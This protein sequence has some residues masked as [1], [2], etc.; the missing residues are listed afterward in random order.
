M[1]EKRNVDEFLDLWFDDKK[2]EQ[3]KMPIPENPMVSKLSKLFRVLKTDAQDEIFVSIEDYYSRQETSKKLTKRTIVTLIILLLM[4]PLTIAFGILFMGDRKYTF[5]GIM[6][7]FYAIIPF[8]MGFESRKPQT[9]ELIVIAV[10]SAIAVL[11]RTA[12][13][14]VPMFKPILA[15]IIISGVTFGPEAGF[16]VGAVS[17]FISNFFFGQGPWTPWQMFSAGIIGFVA[18]VLFRKGLLKRTRVS[19][20]L[21]GFLAAIFIYG[22]IMNPAAL[23]MYTSHITIEGIIGIYI[24]GIPVDLAHA[25]SVVIFLWLISKGMIEKLERIK[26]KYGLLV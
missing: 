14:M 7:M 21:F 15:I 18:G 2:I 1:S 16:L 24:S 6:L 9:R 3:Y 23:I 22:G 26:K 12:F 5:I 8:F 17:M 20:C 4:S 10:L 11:G 13:I 19:L 25:T